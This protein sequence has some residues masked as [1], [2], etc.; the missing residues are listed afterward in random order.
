VVDYREIIPNHG[1]GLAEIF[2]T[3]E[4]TLIILSGLGD[5]TK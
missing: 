2:V 1:L 5:K 3:Y 4:N